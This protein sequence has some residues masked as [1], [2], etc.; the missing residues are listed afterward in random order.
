MNPIQKII[1]TNDEEF[2]KEFGAIHP[3]HAKPAIRT[4]MHQ[5]DKKI[6]EGVL[7]ML[8]LYRSGELEEGETYAF[9][10]GRNAC[11][12]EIRDLL[13]QAIKSR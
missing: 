11:L 8:P 3:I 7:E 4:F 10:G 5:R 6:L 13:E 1:E 2:Y 12:K 9:R